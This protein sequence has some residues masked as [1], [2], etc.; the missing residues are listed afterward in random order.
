MAFSQ[1]VSCPSC[2]APAEVRFPSLKQATCEYCETIFTFNRDGVQNSGKKS[3]VIQPI[4]G[5]TLHQEIEVMGQKYEVIGRVTYGYSRENG[6]LGGV[7]DEW[8][9]ES[10]S[11]ELW[12]T[13][14]SGT[15]ILENKL[16]PTESIHSK[17]NLEDSFSFEDS[18]Y[19]VTEIGTVFCKGVSGMLPFPLIPDESYY[20]AD[21]RLC[22]GRGHDTISL[23]YDEDLPTLFTGK[24]LNPDELKYEQRE[25]DTT[26]KDAEALRCNSCGSPLSI[27]GDTNRIQTIVCASCQTINEIRRDVAISIGK[28]DILLE[29]ELRLP[30]NSI[31]NYKNIEYMVTGRL[32]QEW[33]EDDEQG[34]VKEYFLY[35]PQ[36]GYLYI[37]E[38]DGSYTAW[39]PHLPSEK[40]LHKIFKEGEEFQHSI[41]GETYEFL[42]TGNLK[43]VYVDGS[44]PYAAKLGDRTQFTDAESDSGLYSEE[45]SFGETGPFELEQYRGEEIPLSTLYKSYP[46]L[47]PPPR[48][49]RTTNWFEFALAV[50]GGIAGIYLLVYSFLI[51]K[52]IPIHMS[53]YTQNDLK[54]NEILTDDFL[55]EKEDETIEIRLE[56]GV[57]QS[58]THVGIALL[59]KD[60]EEVIAA[61]DLGIEYYHGTE[62]GESWSEGSSSESIYW[63][64]REPGNYQ[65]MLTVFDGDTSIFTPIN[66][67]IEKNAIRTYP[68]VIMGVLWFF[69]PVIYYF[70]RN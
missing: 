6:N 42:E 55:I 3:Q 66:V 10:N 49:P 16:S 24:I 53:S 20:Y 30:L 43:L 14:D 11:G 17:F 54:G 38:E 45:I 65:L 69:I 58:W 36:E 23:E 21:A 39:Y 59:K 61:E 13:E 2:G 4:S 40:P 33:N 35:N 63:K 44:L 12:L 64:I 31:F 62:D 67:T 26:Q 41:N 46:Q 52:Q 19:I 68:I 56:T 70:R 60:A 34:Y 37:D 50:L 57:D 28:V 5:I 29:E 7:W 15:F 48:P 27:E 25:S 8:Y 18:R 51:D 32:I 22:S 1:K 47:K 9:L